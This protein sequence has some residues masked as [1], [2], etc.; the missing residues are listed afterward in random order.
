MPAPYSSFIKLPAA[1]TC[2][3]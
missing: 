2:N 3:G 1:S